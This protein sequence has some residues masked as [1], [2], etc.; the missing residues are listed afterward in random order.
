MKK[1]THQ[2][3]TVKV[4][5]MQNDKEKPTDTKLN[6]INEMKLMKVKPRSPHSSG[7]EKVV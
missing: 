1:I 5:G 7:G 3:C 4:M 2:T 6:E